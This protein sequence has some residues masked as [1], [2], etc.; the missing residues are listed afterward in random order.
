MPHRYLFPFVRFKVDLRELIVCFR[1]NVR[2][3]IVIKDINDILDYNVW[4]GICWLQN[5]LCGLPRILRSRLRNSRINYNRNSCL[6]GNQQLP[7]TKAREEKILR[8]WI[9]TKL[10]KKGINQSF[11]SYFP[12]FLHWSYHILHDPFSTLLRTITLITDRFQSP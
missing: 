7:L 2:G 6:H 9:L 8:K 5:T 10:K 3:L 11:K 1:M 12:S 4:R